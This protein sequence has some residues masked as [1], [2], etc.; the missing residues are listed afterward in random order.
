MKSSFRSPTFRIGAALICLMVLTQ[1]SCTTLQLSPSFAPGLGETDP[2]EPADSDIGNSST[3]R[4]VGIVTLAVVGG[5]I[6]YRVFIEDSEET[7][8]GPKPDSSSTNGWVGES[9]LRPVT[10]L[11]RDREIRPA[12]LQPL[13]WGDFSRG[14]L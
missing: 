4:T 11:N 14:G 10:R 5:Y 8:T 3:G 6:L 7:T 12:P 9:H 13:W 1:T 2:G